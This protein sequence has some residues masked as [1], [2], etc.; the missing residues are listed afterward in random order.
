[1][2]K[3]LIEITCYVILLIMSAGAGFMLSR[4]VSIYQKSK[5]KPAYQ[6]NN[7]L[8]SSYQMP[9][10]LAD[11]ENED[12][13]E[14]EDEDEIDEIDE[15][16]LETVETNESTMTD[17]D[18]DLI[19]PYEQHLYKTY[20]NYYSQ[21]ISPQDWGRITSGRDVYTIQK[22]DTLWD[23]SKVLFDDPNYWPKLWSVNPSLGNPH[24]ILPGKSLGFIYGTIGQAPSMVILD[25]DTKEQEKLKE[26]K[27]PLPDFLKNAEIKVPPP[28]KSVPVLTELPSSLPILYFQSQDSKDSLVDLEIKYE[29][30]TM[31]HIASL[32]YY[33]S[34]HQ[35]SGQGKIVDKKH[36]GIWSSTD[37]RIILEMKEPVNPGQKLMIV[38]NL[39][40]L[41]PQ[42]PGIRGPFG[43]QIEVQGEVQVVGRIKDSFDLYEANVTQTLSPIVTKSYVVTQQAPKFDF[44]P[45]NINGTGEEAQ[46]IGFPPFAKN[47]KKGTLYGLLYLNRGSK[48]GF[49]IG[50][51]Y[52][53]QAN[54]GV[55]K[56]FPYGYKIKMGELKII[57]V[58]D[59]FS[60][61]LI[62][63]MSSSIQLGDHI[64]SMNKSILSKES[65]YDPLM[66]EDIVEDF[67][68]DMEEENI[69]EDFDEEDVYEE[70]I[71]GENS[72][73]E[74]DTY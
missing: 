4:T 53:V 19:D 66:E 62:T 35:I 7:R 11:S 51:M 68:E 71:N 63:T 8:P 12:E 74:E 20:I 3:T 30:P 33:M 26:E 40:K 48:S 32:S 6:P 18:D 41:V 67:D 10:Q 47:K 56:D 5:N 23:I 38:Q 14:D 43:Y 21:Q 39:G 37:E 1:M 73:E 16:Q 29:K 17:L 72:E 70:N 58:E 54:P 27:E 46:I 60:T 49:S 36:G 24:F 42:G 59:H 69:I 28:K 52:Q 55:R 22:S 65:G 2:K 15:I 9:R 44:K 45:T 31:T 34:S 64:I 61:G 57:H 13:D 25:P 50:Q